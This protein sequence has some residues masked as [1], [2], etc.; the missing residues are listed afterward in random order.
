MKTYVSTVQYCSSD[1]CKKKV[2]STKNYCVS[3]LP[4]NAVGSERLLVTTLSK[5]TE[6]D[7]P[8]QVLHTIILF[9]RWRSSFLR[10]N[11]CKKNHIAIQVI[12]VNVQKTKYALEHDPF[13]AYNLR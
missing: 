10:H 12:R 13:R 6:T 1:S 8:Y 4:T 11:Y 7:Y 9:W 3:I 5:D 2:R